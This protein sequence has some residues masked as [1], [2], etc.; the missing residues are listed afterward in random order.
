MR[1][2]LRAVPAALLLAAASAQGQGSYV[3]FET[4]PTRPVALSPD[5]NTL[6]VT[7]TPDNRVELFTVTAGGLVHRGGVPVGMNVQP[8]M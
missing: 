7:N 5:G 4:V 1:R 3:N 8:M 6:A 2:L